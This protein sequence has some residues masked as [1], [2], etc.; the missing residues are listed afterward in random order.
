MPSPFDSEAAFSYPRDRDW[1]TDAIPEEGR[2]HEPAAGG[3]LG[4][5]LRPGRLQPVFDHVAEQLARRDAVERHCPELERLRRPVGVAEPKAARDRAPRARLDPEHQPHRVLC[6]AGERLVCRCRGRPADPAVWQHGSGGLDR[7][8]SGRVRDQLPGRAH[9]RRGGRGADRLGHGHPAAHCP[10]HRGP[11]LVGHHSS[12]RSRWQD[13][14]RIRRAAGGADP[15]RGH[16]GGRREG[17]VQDRH[18]RHRSL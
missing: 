7:R 16:Q 15:H 9:L 11:R 10:G 13:L 2:R 8:G 1:R 5:R 17:H 6:R 18:P 14:R 4:H 3:G 12:A